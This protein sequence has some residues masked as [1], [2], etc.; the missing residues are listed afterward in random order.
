VFGACIGRPRY[1]AYTK[2]PHVASFRGVD[3]LDGAFVEN[4]TA[5]VNCPPCAADTDYVPSVEWLLI[6]PVAA[7]LI[8]AAIGL[9]AAFTAGASERGQD[10]ATAERAAAWEAGFS[11]EDLH[12]LAGMAAEARARLEAERVEVVLAHGSGSGD[13]VVV[14][15]SRLEP[16]RIGQ[17]IVRGDDELAGRALAA[18]RTVL[19]PAGEEAAEAHA[20]EAVAVPITSHGRVVGVLAA[21][22]PQDGGRFGPGH[23]ARLQALA[24]AGGARLSPPARGVRRETG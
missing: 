18:G 20:H 5:T 3:R 22:A 15:G 24:D 7:I 14:T 10:V 2:R 12:L 23:A 13:A 8:A 19:A 6:L 17:R 11:D 21:T 1:R 4:R 9:A 16:G